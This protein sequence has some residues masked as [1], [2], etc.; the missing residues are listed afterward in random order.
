MTVEL[1]FSEKIAQNSLVWAAALMK[2]GGVL[3]WSDDDE[4]DQYFGRPYFRIK[5]EGW[6][7]ELM[8][9]AFDLLAPPVPPSP[10]ERTA[11]AL[12]ELVGAQ[13]AEQ[14]ERDEWE[15]PGVEELR[16]FL[17]LNFQVLW[18]PT[19]DPTVAY[20]EP[21]DPEPTYR[22]AEEPE[23]SVQELPPPRLEVF[24]PRVPEDPEV[25]LVRFKAVRRQVDA[26][27]PSV[28]A[29]IRLVATQGDVGTATVEASYYRTV[30]AAKAEYAR[31]VDLG[32]PDPLG[33]VAMLLDQKRERAKILIGF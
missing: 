17:A 3:T 28:A 1:I 25:H 31:L 5:M 27:S 33:A 13:Q 29:A 8:S 32:A 24:K 23:E 4:C 19:D 12:E 2:H 26:G 21:D 30:N 18:V 11:A 20:V 7:K 22:L 10:M 15:P 16:E 14:A 6:P 9:L